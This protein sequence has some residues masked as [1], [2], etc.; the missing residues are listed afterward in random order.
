[1]IVLAPRGAATV[2]VPGSAYEDVNI[3]P[4]ASPVVN[5]AVSPEP[6]D[7][8]A[9]VN[10]GK[11]P[12]P[13]NPSA[14]DETPA[15]YASVKKP[16]PAEPAPVQAGPSGSVKPKPAA[17]PKP[18]KKGKPEKAKGKKKEKTGDTLTY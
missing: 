5:P 15:V 2:G 8:Y 7:V 13:Q 18:G 10:K 6:T 14:A 12:P 17:K 16:K 4:G 3:T 9:S 1:M 11:K